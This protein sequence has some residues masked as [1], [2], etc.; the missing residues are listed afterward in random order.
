MFNNLLL[1]DCILKGPEYYPFDLA[2]PD[3]IIRGVSQH[4]KQITLD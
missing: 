2:P 3:K 4:Y 1:R